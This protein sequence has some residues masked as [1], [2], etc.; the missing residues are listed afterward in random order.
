MT[1]RLV[2]LRICAAAAVLAFAAGCTTFSNDGGFGAV[3]TAASERLG[4]EAV[5][6]KTDADRDAVARRTQELLSKP[7]SVDDAV[8]I[9]LL[10]NRGLQ[11]SYAAL[12]LS[13]A[14]LVQAG[15]LPNPGFTFSRTRSSN[16]LSIGRTFSMGVL[17]MLTLPLATKIEGRRFE[18]TKLETADAM[19]KVAADARRAY[20]E[21][22]AAAQAATYAEQVKDSAD[23]GAEL[24]R[25][26][27]QAGSFSRLDYA[28]E[29]AFYADAIAQLANARQRA[30]AAREKLTRT[31]GLWGASTEYELPDRLPDP[32]AE[33]PQLDGLERFAMENRL[34]IQAAKLRTQGVATSLGLTQA[35]RFVNALD[36]GYLDNYETDKGHEHGYEISVEIPLFDWGGAKVARAKAIY[37]QSA[38]RLAQ[39]A[40]DARSEVRESYAAY[41]TRYDVAKH[42]RDEVVPL[43]KTIS[44]E[45]LLRYNGM[46]VSVF[47]LLADA[48]DQV[49]AVNGYIDALKDYWLAETDLR[50]AVGGRLPHGA[51][52]AGESRPAAPAAASASAASPSSAASSASTA[53]ASAI[54]SPAS[55]ASAATAPATA[56]AHGQAA[57]PAAP[58]ASST[59][60]EGK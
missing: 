25:R 21:A 46:L 9:A 5:L 12:G 18:Q 34:D 32:P 49:G 31:M 44:D 8:Q 51:D 57:A 28:R 1:P 30:V 7:L 20:V 16:D 10:N 43:R 55:A 56:H 60:P 3:S 41:V 54:A 58:P 4:K 38:N 22:V 33:R 39:T 35:T 42:Y 50:Q 53:S 19:L 17:S 45:M 26:M 24:A 59:N 13:E 14:D 47:E 27:R 40:I 6:V 29:Q 2:S 37:L 11:A 48:R 36:V 23:A 52:A 15:R